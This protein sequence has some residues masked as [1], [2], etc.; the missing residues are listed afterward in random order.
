[1]PVTYL[2]RDILFMKRIAVF[3]ACILVLPLLSCDESLPLYE[4]PVPS[5]SA[6]L[7]VDQDPVMLFYGGYTQSVMFRFYVTNLYEE[8]IEDQFFFKGHIECRLRNG[9]EVLQRIEFEKEN[10][11]MLYLIPNQPHEVRVAWDQQCANGDYLWDY[12]DAVPGRLYLEA[13]GS[14]QVFRRYGMVPAD[15]M[16]FQV[17]YSI[18]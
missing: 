8:V 18:R 12:L 6:R 16:E 9:T 7:T 13:T 4:E 1:M 3:F 10:S 11:S 15:R 17:A 2:T 5:F 14:I